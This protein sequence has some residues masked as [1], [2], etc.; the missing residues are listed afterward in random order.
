M[1]NKSAKMSLLWR[2]SETIG[3]EGVSFAVFAVL[4]RALAPG[5]FGSVALFRSMRCAM[6]A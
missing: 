1:I 6:S 5:E 2:V 3:S 4:A